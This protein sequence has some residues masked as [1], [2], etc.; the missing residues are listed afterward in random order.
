MPFDGTN[1]DS[2]SNADATVVGTPGFAGESAFGSDAYQGAAGAYLSLPIAN[3]LAD[4]F[5]GAFWY[6]VSG[7]PNRAGILTVAPPRVDDA[8]VRS[9]GFRLFREGSATEQR[10]KLQIGDG[11]G[12]VWNDGEVID[13]TAGEWVH[14]A[15]TVTEDATQ[16]YFNG[17]A[18]ANSGN[19][20][21]KTISWAGCTDITIG[22]GAPN[23]I[24][25]NHLSDT[26]IIDELYMFDKVLTV[27]EIQAVMAN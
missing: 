3:V 12:D 22:S 5:T 16:I 11:T 20:T 17:T 10:I 27:E 26:S 8:D 23:F 6:K 7:D 21:G 4:Q 1:K 18:V 14:I 25:W 15:F 19:M 2:V 24:G 9:S 13:V